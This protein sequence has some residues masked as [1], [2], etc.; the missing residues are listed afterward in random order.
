ML[1]LTRHFVLYIFDVLMILM[2]S[3]E[4]VIYRYRFFDTYYLY[5]RPDSGRSQ[6]FSHFYQHILRHF[7]PPSRGVKLSSLSSTPTQK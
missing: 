2:P 1:V 6:R 7:G 5:K 3:I 4:S